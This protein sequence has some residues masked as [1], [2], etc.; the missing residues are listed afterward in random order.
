MCSVFQRETAQRYNHGPSLLYS[1]RMST[2]VCRPFGDSDIYGIGDVY[3]FETVRR[4]K[5]PTGTKAF[6]DAE[7]SCRTITRT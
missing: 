6:K 7:K 4:K 1:L 5:C 3:R 2:L